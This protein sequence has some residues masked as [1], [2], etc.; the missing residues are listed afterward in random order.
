MEK[1]STICREAVKKAPSGLS[2]EAIA[3][4]VGKKYKTLMSELA[5]SR[6]WT[7]CPIW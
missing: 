7:F 3:D 2:A 5:T 4:L 1:L 6:T